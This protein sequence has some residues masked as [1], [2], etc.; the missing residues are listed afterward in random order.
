MEKWNIKHTLP[1]I[2]IRVTAQAAVILIFLAGCGNTDAL[3]EARADV[4]ARTCL[5]AVARQLGPS[6][7]TVELLAERFS[8]DPLLPQF[9]DWNGSRRS[10]VQ[11]I[12][13]VCRAP[14]PPVGERP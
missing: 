1:L 6:D 2:R 8:S 10:T 9:V 7:A 12:R 11:V 4:V 14:A 13:L 3:L 5:S